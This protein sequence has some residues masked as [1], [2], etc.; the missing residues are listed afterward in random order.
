MNKIISA[1]LGQPEPDVAKA[2]AK[3]E[4]K[5]GYP[6]HDVRHLAENI[7]KTRVKLA[8][9][10]LDPDDTTGEELYH[11]LLV[12]F[13]QDSRALD[14]QSSFV[15]NS[16]DDKAAKAVEIVSKNLDLSE[17]WALKNSSAKNILRQHPP[18]KLMKHLDYRSVESL[19]KRE[20]LAAIYLALD[21][22]ESNAWLSD[23]TKLISRQNSTA[24]QPRPLS[25]NYLSQSKWG[26]FDSP[27]SLIYNDDFAVVGLIAANHSD[28]ASVLSLAVLL[29]DSLANFQ[30]INLS[31]EVSRLNPVLAWWSDV[32]GLISNLAD[33]H[34]SLNLADVNSSHLHSKTYAERAIDNSRRSFWQELLSR[35]DN[36]LEAE[37][38]IFSGIKDQMINFK[39]PINQPA[40]EYAEDI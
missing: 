35:Y 21:F 30:A 26:N 6:S 29:I 33:E 12:K 14:A 1:I 32:D 2:I 31:R 25:L 11:V 5:N 23:H 36:Q 15:S 28:K 9:L 4:A 13:E 3:L 10:G 22:F 19:L 37:E 8:E 18:K 17:R 20:N 24:Y 38:D 27:N 7:Q 40:F 39:T 16:F 34:V